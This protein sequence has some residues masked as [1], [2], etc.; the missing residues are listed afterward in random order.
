MPASSSL[1]GPEGPSLSG[2]DRRALIRFLEQSLDHGFCLAIV[3]AATQADRDDILAEIAPTIGPRLFAVAVD[4]LPGA[5]TNLWTALREPFNTHVPRCLALWGLDSHSDSEWARQL[6]VQRDLFVS[7]FAVPWLLF[8]HPA[9][10]VALLQVAPDFCDFAILWLRDESPLQAPIVSMVM[11]TQSHSLSSSGPADHDPLLQQARAALDEARFDAAR[12]ALSQFDLQ[13]AH[14]IF[15]HIRRQLY[16]ARLER[17]LG[18][19][20]LA[21]ALV[22]DARNTLERQPSTAETQTLA[23]LADAEFAIVLAQ[24]A[25]YGEA[26]TLLRRILQ[27][28]EHALGREHADYAVCLS[29]L[30]DVLA[31]QSKYAEAELIARDAVAI[32]ARTQGR[33]HHV[34]S[35]ALTSLGATLSAQGKYAEAEHTF[36]DSLEI[37]LS[38]LGRDH[39]SYGISLHNLAHVLSAQGKYVEAESGLRASLALTDKVLGREHPDYAGSLQSLALLL[40]KQG[41]HSEAESLLRTSVDLL[42]R[43]LGREHPNYSTSLHNLAV[44]LSSRGKYAEAERILR[45]VIALNAKA[46]GREHPDYGASLHALASALAVR[47]EYAEAEGILRESLSISEKT[48]GH[49]NPRLCPTLA[50]LA[51]NVARQGRTREAIRLLERALS[52]G[53]ATLGAD[54]P[55]V[56]HMQ[57]LLTQFQRSRRQYR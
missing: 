41:R 43:A 14:D 26:E 31:T 48:L 3:E 29:N 56:H 57:G 27:H 53:R 15:D 1:P 4:E 23:R 54:H 37:K 12:D 8:I 2:V 30:A 52:I 51:I 39:L 6:N 47:G 50:N 11:G 28:V 7:D 38:A 42:E 22:R 55:E 46:P 32:L 45:E 44:E 33:E 5:D 40:S 13:S 18:H 25:R 17:E 35:A 49:A 19:P 24:S 20:A 10:R 36:R 21:E 34:Y 9:S 16:G